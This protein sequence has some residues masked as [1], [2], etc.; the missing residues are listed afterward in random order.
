[1][2]VISK[3]YFLRQVR[4][5]TQSIGEM[6]DF[7]KSEIPRR[8]KWIFEIRS[9][10]LAIRECNSMCLPSLFIFRKGAERAKYA[11]GTWLDCNLFAN[12]SIIYRHQYIK[13][14]CFETHKSALRFIFT[15][16]E[17]YFHICGK[18]FSRLWKIVFTYVEKEL[19]RQ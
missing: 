15:I 1:M 4:Q 13:S 18:T 19:V 10:T 8:K 6:S 2:P 17:N 16:V 7:R 11:S 3:L 5:E 12:I 9:D 14:S